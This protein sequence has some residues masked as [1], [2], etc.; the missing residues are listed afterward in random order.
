MEEM[1]GKCKSLENVK[2]NFQDINEIS[3]KILNMSLEEAFMKGHLEQRLADKNFEMNNL[4]EE[5]E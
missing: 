2:R 5:I 3:F 4:I 1:V